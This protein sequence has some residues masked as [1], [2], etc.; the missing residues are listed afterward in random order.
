MEFMSAGLVW[1]A[2]VGLRLWLLP[3]GAFCGIWNFKF[4]GS[5]IVME[6]DQTGGRKIFCTKAGLVVCSWRPV[7]AGFRRSC[8]AWQPVLG[9]P[10]RAE[11]RGRR[12]AAGENLSLAT[13]VDGRLTGKKHRPVSTALVRVERPVWPN[14][15]AAAAAARNALLILGRKR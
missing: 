9:P 4:L 10:G 1:G 13:E 6:A 5:I 15:L 14:T 11:H 8:L 7:V 3:S 12:G 2:A